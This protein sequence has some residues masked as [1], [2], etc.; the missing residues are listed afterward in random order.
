MRLYNMNEVAELIGRS[1]S[2]IYGIVLRGNV[3]PSMQTVGDKWLFTDDDVEQ[4]K[5]WLTRK[6]DGRIENGTAN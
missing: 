6:T 5:Q 2:T 4:L 3:V 1:Y